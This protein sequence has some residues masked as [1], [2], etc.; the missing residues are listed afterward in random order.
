M[1][2]NT[3]GERETLPIFGSKRDILPV[4]IYLTAGVTAEHGTYILDGNPEHV[5]HMLWKTGLSP[6]VSSL[7]S[8]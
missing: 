2:V 8:I 4:D 3:E 6:S 5:A 1:G 7:L